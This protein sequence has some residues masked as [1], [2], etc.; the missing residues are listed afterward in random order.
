MRKRI[1]K[2]HIIEGACVQNIWRTLITQQLKSKPILKYTKE[3]KS[4]FSKQHNTGSQ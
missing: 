3:M 2:L 1:F 4:H